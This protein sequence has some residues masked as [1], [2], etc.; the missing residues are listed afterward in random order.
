M[1][2]FSKHFTYPFRF[3]LPHSHHPVCF[4]ILLIF[5]LLFYPP[6]FISPLNATP[7]TH[8]TPPQL[9]PLSAYI[10]D[11]ACTFPCY[12]SVLASASFSLASNDF[13][14]FLTNF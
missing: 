4:H 5:Y 7:A 6:P 14:H 12:L 1:P 13:F 11:I 10:F 3:T 8:S 9:P 2:L